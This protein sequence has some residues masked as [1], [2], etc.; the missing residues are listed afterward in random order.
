MLCSETMA[1]RS[2]DSQVTPRGTI[3]VTTQRFHGPLWV[4]T[5][6]EFDGFPNFPLQTH[7]IT[8]PADQP[9]ALHCQQINPLHY[10]TSR[11]TPFITLPADQ[12]ISLHCLLVILYFATFYTQYRILRSILM[13][14]QHYGYVYMAMFIWLFLYGYAT[15]WLCLYVYATL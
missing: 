12:P 6:G 13:A 7:C 4:Q 1:T 10:T 5:N 3:F 14:L 2:P 11:S 9:I 8:L 15:L